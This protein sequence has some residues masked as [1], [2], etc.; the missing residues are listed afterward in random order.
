MVERRFE[1]VGGALCLD[2]VNTVGDRLATRQ[3]A[4]NYLERYDDLVAWGLQSHVLT[5]SEATVLRRLAAR[6]PD[7]ASA[8]LARAVDAR[9]HLHNALFAA[10]KGRAIA[11]ETLASLNGAIAPLLAL[12]RLVVKDREWRWAF[13]GRSD[14]ELLD[15][16]LWGVVRS[17]I[18][19]LTSA[20]LTKIQRCGVATC[21]WL[22]LDLSRNRTR[23]WCSMAMCGNRTKARRHRASRQ[24]PTSLPDEASPA[25][26]AAHS[27]IR[28]PR[29]AAPS[30][31]AGRK[32]TAG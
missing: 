21:G 16:V 15:R 2:F 23:R 27:G 17:A 11:G 20:N 7:Q 26:S 1:L 9:E 30:S 4:R 32:T 8:A 28:A 19:L 5:P 25:R 12:S 6:R 3:Y 29:R 13:G 10:M 18:E 22:F 31:S 24:R 14:T